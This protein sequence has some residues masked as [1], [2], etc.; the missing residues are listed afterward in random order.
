MQVSGQFDVKTA[1]PTKIV[2]GTHWVVLS[3]PNGPSGYFY[4]GQKSLASAWKG[5]I[6][7]RG[8]TSRE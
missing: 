2:Q 3:G 5:A 1:L 6:S 4:W 7:Q 8:K